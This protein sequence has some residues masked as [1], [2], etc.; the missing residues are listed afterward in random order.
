[1]F[2]EAEIA[3]KTTDAVKD[4]NVPQKLRLQ[5][6]FCTRC[7]INEICAMITKEDEE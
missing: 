1:M 6:S 2:R 3:R 7:V 5:C 4:C